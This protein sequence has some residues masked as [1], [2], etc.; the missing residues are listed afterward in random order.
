MAD[1]AAEYDIPVYT[2]ESVNTPEWI[3]Q[4]R[5]WQPDLIFSFYYRNMITEEILQIPRLG[6]FNMH[7]SLLPKYRGRVPINW[8]VLHG[9]KETGVT[10]HHMVKTRRRRRHRGPGSGPDR[11]RR[12]GPGRL[13]QGGHR[14][15]ASVLERQLDALDERHGP[16][17]ETGRITGHLLRRHGSPRT[18]VSTGQWTRKRYIIW[19]AP[20]P[21]PIPGPL[22]CIDGKKLFL[23]RA[24]P[25]PESAGGPERSCRRIRSAI[26]AGS[27]GLEIVKLQ[28]EGR[29]EEDAADGMH[30]LQA[31]ELLGNDYV[32]HVCD[33]LNNTERRYT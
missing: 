31:G 28:W 3:E 26:A 23:W 18:D 32:Q 14:R 30:G 24:R 4:I 1:L 6:A 21:I 15:P 5:A 27:G 10:L 22:P 16:P 19:S 2:P 13:P 29:H 17:A 8:A 11:S 12:H 25:L 33:V 20:S 7:G 9:E